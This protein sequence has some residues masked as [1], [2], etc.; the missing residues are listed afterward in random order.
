MG[1]FGP[2]KKKVLVVDDDENVRTMLEMA[3][4]G[5]GYDVDTASTGTEGIKRLT[6]KSY[7]LAILDHYMPG[8]TGVEI[9]EVISN[10]P[11]AKE[12][13]FIMLTA[14]SQVR[15]IDRAYAF[16]AKEYIVK[17]FEIA[18]FLK[19]VAAVMAK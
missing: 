18:T 3:L 17:P 13:R 6:Q 5:A 10:S 8:A 15:V 9:L 1:I 11:Y 4:S 12:T 7:D 16:R 19:K 14:E 2:S